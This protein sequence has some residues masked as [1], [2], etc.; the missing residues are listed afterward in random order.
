MLKLTRL[1]GF[2]AARQPTD[3]D[4]TIGARAANVD[5]YSYLTAHGYRR[6]PNVAVTIAPGVQ[7]YSSTTARPG[8]RVNL[9]EFPNSCRIV[10]INRGKICGRG[11]ASGAAGGK[12][13]QVWG[14]SGA[15]LAINNRGEIN[16]GGGGGKRGSSTSC[17]YRVPDGKSTSCSGPVTTCAGGAGGT[18]Y[19]PNAATSGSRGQS[20]SCPGCRG[21]TGRSGSAG[22]GKGQRGGGSG[23]SAGAAVTGN[24]NIRWTRTGTRNGT[25]S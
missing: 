15:T 23:G 14:G 5:L 24:A 4:L 25:V 18:G 2:G 21:C 13:L 9:A 11:G 19:G 22:G 17:R 16:G 20:L 7:V 3:F 8:L 10:L 12:A 6:E 1:A